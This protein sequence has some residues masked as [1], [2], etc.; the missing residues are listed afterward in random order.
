MKYA[1]VAAALVGS[2][3]ASQHK[4]HAGFHQRRHDHAAAA[5]EDV[6]TVYTTVYVTGPPPSYPTATPEIPKP[7]SPA[8][9]QQSQPPVHPDTPMPSPP[10]VYPQ[11]S[12]PPQ[13]GV[14]ASTSCDEETPKPTGPAP[15]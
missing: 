2:V 9:P 12:Q 4:A 15:G 3:F 6:C 11:G 7:S 13:P 10:P 5:Q 14:P 1:F 8:V